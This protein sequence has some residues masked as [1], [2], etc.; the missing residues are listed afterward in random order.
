V[1]ILLCGIGVS[2]VTSRRYHFRF[3]ARIIFKKTRPPLLHPLL[4]SM[5]AL[6]LTA[7][8]STP[9]DNT[10]KLHT[11]GGGTVRKRRGA[12]AAILASNSFR[13]LVLAESERLHCRW[14]SPKTP[15]PPEGTPASL[16]VRE[17]GKGW[18]KGI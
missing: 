14:D 10:S 1:L 3:R 8:S 15:P 2:G 7:M 13:S 4:P 12:S 18:G 16:Y 6:A 11:C 9:N 17:T 5:Q